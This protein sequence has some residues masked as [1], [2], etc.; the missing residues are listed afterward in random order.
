MH[1]VAP[2][3]R[4]STALRRRHAATQIAAAQEWQAKDDAARAEVIAMRNNLKGK[5]YAYNHK[6]ELTVVHPMNPDALPHYSNVNMHFSTSEQAAP[7]ALRALKNQVANL[8]ALPGLGHKSAAASKVRRRAPRLL[9][10]YL[11]S[12]AARLLH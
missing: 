8:M 11:R 10:C 1:T 2:G 3:S 12:L 7:N 9:P 6:G 5:G 4:L